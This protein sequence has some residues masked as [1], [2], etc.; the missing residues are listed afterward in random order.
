MCSLMD[1]IFAVALKVLLDCAGFLLS[2]CR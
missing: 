1:G 2:A